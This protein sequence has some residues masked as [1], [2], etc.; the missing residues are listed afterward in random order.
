MSAT[1]RGSERVASDFYPTPSWCTR[2]LLETA[3]LPN[4]SRSV[5]F[6]PC[7]GDGAIVRV[8]RD[9]FPAVG[10]VAQ[11]I[12]PNIVDSVK[13]AGAD[14]LLIGDY[15][16]PL[17]ASVHTRFDVGITNPPFDLAEQVVLTMLRHCDYVA[18][19]VRQGFV[20]HVRAK[21]MREDMPDTYELP[22]RPSFVSKGTC[23]ECGAS[24][25]VQHGAVASS[26]MCG[27][28]AR[29]RFSQATDAADYCWLVW[30]VERGR[31]E[32]KRVILES[33]PREE[34]KRG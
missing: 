33:T 32:G 23:K 6:E 19:L 15:L 2:R 8:V 9:K 24:Q 34:R 22:E 25:L 7:A 5:W 28:G 31:R 1:G 20:G 27:C 4:Y 18:V 11:E 13:A 14:K 3:W 16:S 30:T 21:W 26:P 17:C 10:I 29:M 12:R